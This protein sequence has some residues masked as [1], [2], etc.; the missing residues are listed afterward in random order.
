MTTW[1]RR[2]APKYDTFGVAQAAF[3]YKSTRISRKQ[4][5]RFSQV[6]YGGGI[7]SRVVIPQ[8]LSPV[9]KYAEQLSALARGPLCCHPI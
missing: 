4:S 1:P 8:S 7:H 2:G 5:G 6:R 3:Q 9:P